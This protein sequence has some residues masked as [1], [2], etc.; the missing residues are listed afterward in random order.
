MKILS[1]TVDFDCY[2]WE[3]PGDYPNGIAARA[4]PSYPVC[5][6]SGELVIELED[7][8]DT[9]EIDDWFGDWVDSKL[10]H[11]TPYG[12]RIDWKIEVADGKITATPNDAT[13]VDY[14]DYDR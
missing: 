10:R 8:D 11:S 2:I 3:D 6:F 12:W 9:S 14:G 7:G 1:D 5:D 13:A 4:L